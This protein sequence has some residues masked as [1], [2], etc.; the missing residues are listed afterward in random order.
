MG[1]SEFIIYIYISKR[2]T[3]KLWKKLDVDSNQVHE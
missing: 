1:G 3:K 2:R